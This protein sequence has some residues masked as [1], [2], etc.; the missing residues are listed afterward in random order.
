MHALIDG[1]ILAY[2]F[3]SC[4]Y[5]NGEPLGWPLVVS[6]LDARIQGIV[7]AVEADTYSIYLTSDDKSNFR[8]DC[9]IERSENLVFGHRHR[10][11]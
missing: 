8:I 4:S 2:E 7:N 11:D 5:E 10:V 3:G 6:R 1:D 9:A